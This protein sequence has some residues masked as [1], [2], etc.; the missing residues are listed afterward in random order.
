[1]PSRHSDRGRMLAKALRDDPE[2]NTAKV[3]AEFSEPYGTIASVNR[4]REGN[5]D[6]FDYLAAIPLAGMLPRMLK[7]GKKLIN[8]GKVGDDGFNTGTAFVHVNRGG[9]VG[10]GF[11]NARLPSSDP[12]APF[13]AH[14][15]TT[16]PSPQTAYR[17]GVDGDTYTPVHIKTGNPASK[18]DIADAQKAIMEKTKTQAGLD[19]V[20]AAGGG[21][22]A[23]REELASR[24][25]THAVWSGHDAVN[26]TELATTGS[27]SFKDARGRKLKLVWEK[28]K[29]RGKEYPSL[30]LYENGEHITGYTDLADYLDAAPEVSSVA[31]FDPKNIKSVWADEIRKTLP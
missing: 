8:M 10:D 16:E 9:I 12:D 13:N 28:I 30:E 19:E 22:H 25:F 29:V 20:Y 21:S 7:G 6:P 3:M 31:V 26:A 27:T 4:I 18:A 17:G 5:A 2:F 11:D 1:M 24:G 14:W 15:L 23:L